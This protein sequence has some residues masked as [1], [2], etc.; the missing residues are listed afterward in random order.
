M[1]VVV[2]GNGVA[3]TEAALAVRQREPSWKIT[4]VS[5]ESDHFFSRTALM[6]VLSGQMA[7]RDIEPLERDV[8]ARL[9]FERVRARAIGLDPKAHELLLAGGVRLRYDRLLIAAGSR[10]RAP[11]WPGYGTLAGVGHFVTMQDLEW[12][13]AEVHGRR[14]V[15]APPRGDA[16][17]TASTPDSP[18]QPRPVGAKTR[19]TLVQ[20][21]VVVGGGLIGVEVVETL[22]AAG[23][24]P[25][26]LIREEWFWPIA[27]DAN[28]SAWVA[29]A[30][31]HHG[32]DVRL[33]A[34]V[35]RLDGD[36]VVRSVV[37]DQGA[38]DADLVVV[39]IG[40]VPNTAWLGD[41]V[42][43]DPAGGITV[44]ER[45]RTSAPDVWAAGDCA[46]VRWFNGWVRPEQLW[47][48]ARD[49]G[50][51]AGAQMLGDDARY[52][53]GTWYNSAKLMD[54]EYT[55]AGLVNM[56]VDG[57]QSWYFEENGAVRSTTRI[58]HVDGRVVG[59]NF[60][61]RRWDHTVCNR[62]IEQRRHLQYVLEHLDEA[63]FDTEFVP[64]LVV[65]TAA[66]IQLGA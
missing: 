50:R 40:V 12:L 62:W 54:I 18:Y 28:E 47:Y 17:L 21:P 15:D 49:Q 16:H 45:L 23:L 27:L 8:Y 31:R 1:H 61:G 25:T 19:N 14:G 7:Y 3:G 63:R 34:N 6:Y 55:T 44:D 33:G 39:A 13:E 11:E 35:S 51:A 57:E 60:L 10:P 66:R 52:A 29:E 2:V 65:P 46:S 4:I 32:V 26:F 56:R 20:R 53:R 22:L 64:P 38:I 9:G 59:F 58:V 37:T 5:E 42:A 43:R 41:A 48:T 36:G 24:R 30:L